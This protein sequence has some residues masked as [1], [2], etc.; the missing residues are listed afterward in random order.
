MPFR[1]KNTTYGEPSQY[2]HIYAIV[3]DSQLV[4]PWTE[5]L[6][7]LAKSDAPT[8]SL[9]LK[10]P[11]PNI[12]ERKALGVQHGSDLVYYFPDLLEKSQILDVLERLQMS[13]KCFKQR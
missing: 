11:T 1:Q 4:G 6:E 8:W 13:Q 12:K 9:H 2:K 10:E 3:T 5:Y 7:H